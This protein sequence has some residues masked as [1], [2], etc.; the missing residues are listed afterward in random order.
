MS[1]LSSTAVHDDLRGRRDELQSTH[2]TIT[3]PYH[4]YLVRVFGCDC[5][6]ILPVTLTSDAV[7]QNTP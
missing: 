6:P 5:L 1:R 7:M 2:V 4:W 3:Y